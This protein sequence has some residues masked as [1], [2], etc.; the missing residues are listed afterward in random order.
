MRWPGVKKNC[1]SACRTAERLEQQ[2]EWKQEYECLRRE[3]VEQGA[4]R[5]HGLALFLSRGM[6]AWLAALTALKPQPVAQ[7]LIEQSA[8]LPSIARSELTPLLASMVLSCMGKETN[9]L[10][11]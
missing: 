3:A 7:N 2:I 1:N 11:I 5:G 8:N 6:V 9:E 10:S 4:R